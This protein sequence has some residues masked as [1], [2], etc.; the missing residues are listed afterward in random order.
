MATKHTCD[1]P[2]CT[3]GTKDTVK[4]VTLDLTGLS[5]PVCPFDPPADWLVLT[6]QDGGLSVVV[7]CCAACQQAAE[8]A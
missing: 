8:G 6:K 4:E 7:Y 1:N 3:E 2:K 5:T